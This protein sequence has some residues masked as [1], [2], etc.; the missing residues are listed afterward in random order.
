[1][2][3][4]LKKKTKTKAK[5]EAEAEAE[6]ETKTKTKT[7]TETETETPP[8]RRGALDRSEHPATNAARARYAPSRRASSCAWRISH[9]SVCAM[10]PGRRG[11]L[12]RTM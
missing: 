7:E 11:S 5:A 8:A 9:A 6:A 12:G 1:M 3:S 10:S 4:E 2:K